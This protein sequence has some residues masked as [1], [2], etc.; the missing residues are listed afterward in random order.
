MSEDKLADLRAR[1]TDKVNAVE[2]PPGW[3]DLVWQLDQD[4]R[5]IAGDDYSPTRVKADCAQLDFFAVCRSSD[6]ETQRR[7]WERIDQAHADSARTCEECGRPANQVMTS[8]Y[9]M[10]TLCERHVAERR[11]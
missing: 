2:V 1:L 11:L 5:A 6:E 8:R 10:E 9:L 3:V 4:L 7:F